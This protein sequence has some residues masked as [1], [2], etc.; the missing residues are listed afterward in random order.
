MVV[1]YESPG[2][3][4]VRSVSKKTTL[5]FDMFEK[6]GVARLYLRDGV[7]DL[8]VEELS[9]LSVFLTGYPPRQ[10]ILE[11]AAGKEKP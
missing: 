3:L 5:K 8:T 1:E 4:N 7:A 10:E 9:D 11:I 2:W 6:D